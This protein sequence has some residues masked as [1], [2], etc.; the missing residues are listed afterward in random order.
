M[1]KFDASV[2]QLFPDSFVKFLQYLMRYLFWTSTLPFVQ[3]EYAVRG[4][5]VI[6][7]SFVQFKKSRLMKAEP[8]SWTIFWG[9]M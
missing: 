9:M 7:S 1:G 5:S 4:A 8:L 3:G 2:D 6:T